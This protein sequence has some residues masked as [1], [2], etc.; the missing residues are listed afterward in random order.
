MDLVLWEG[1]KFSASQTAFMNP[2]LVLLFLPLVNV[3][4]RGVEK[5]GIRATPLRRM[6]AGMFIAALSFIAISLIQR[7]IDVQGDGKVWVVWQV[8]PYV[9]V[10]IAEVLV[11]VTGLEFAYTQAPAKMKAVILGFW[12][13]SNALAQV[14]VA[15]LA[16][17]GDLS[18]Q[19][20]FWVFS[21]LMLAA[22]AA[23]GVR[24]YFYVY[25]DP[26]QQA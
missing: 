17:F 19:N 25:R 10:T 16:R 14:F 26:Q 18:L 4:V 8:L 1:Q 3:M 21:A 13:L 22:A 6:T 9:L 7:E 5:L 24:A 11:S 23:F 2:L 12:L 15:L 20:F